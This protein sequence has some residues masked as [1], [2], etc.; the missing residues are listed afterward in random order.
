MIPHRS[1]AERLEAVTGETVVDVRE[2]EAAGLTTGVWFVRERAS[3][4]ASAEDPQEALSR[5]VGAR[6]VNAAAWL[7]SR[8][9]RVF[10]DMRGEGL[11]L[12]VFIAAWISSDQIDLTL[13]PQ[14]LLACGRLGLE[15]SLCTND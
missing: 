5:A 4:Y 12:D 8:A 9:T 7:D 6:L 2:K 10:D 14:F 3:H 11:T 1:I 13:P 15:V